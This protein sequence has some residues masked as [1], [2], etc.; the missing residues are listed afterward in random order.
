M[1]YA[2]DF[3]TMADAMPQLVWTA[4]PDGSIDYLNERFIDY[5]GYRPEDI[6]QPHGFERIVHPDDVAA[7]L[8]RWNEALAS[9]EPFETEFRLRRGFD[10]SYRWFL[11]RAL[12]VRNS[13]SEIE[14]W[15]GTA[16]DIDAQKRANESLNLVLDATGLFAAAQDH[17]DLCRRF[18]GLMVQRFADWCV[19]ALYGDDGRLQLCGLR[20]RDPE[21][22]ERWCKLAEQYPLPLDERLKETIE[23][24]TPKIVPLITDD[25]LRRSARSPE[26][27]AELREL[28]LRS[29]IVAPLLHEG[30]ALGAMLLYSAES[31]RVFE[32]ADINVMGTLAERAATAISNVRRIGA[33]HRLRRR[34]QFIGK[35]TEAIYESLDL[36]ASFGEL[37]RL[38]VANFGDFAVTLRLEHETALRVIG[39]AHRDPAKDDIARA[40]V[41][42]RTMHTQAERSFAQSLLD[43]KSRLVRNLDPDTVAESMW[44]YLAQEIIA[45]QPRASITVPLHSRGITYGAIIVYYSCEDRIP[46]ESDEEMLAEIARHASVAME[47]AD[48]FE[49]ERHIAQTLQDSLL[50]PSMPRLE[51]LRFDAVYLPGASAALVGGDWYD[52]WRLEDGAIVINVGDV[53]GRGMDAAIIMGKVRHLMAIAPSYERD[54]ARILDTVESVLGRRYPDVLV[55]AFLGIYDPKQQTLVYAN[56]GHPYPLLRRSMGTEELRAEGLP[57]GLRREAPP[58]ES[59]TVDLSD[60]KLLVLYTDGLTEAHHDVLEGQQRLHEVVNSEAVLHTHN[61]AQFIEESCLG[62]SVDDDVAILTLSFEPSKRWSFDAENARAAQDARG[63]FVHYL[64]RHVVNGSSI[65]AAELVFGELVGNVVRHAPGPIDIDLDWSHEHPI[66]HVIDR[67]KPFEAGGT[68]PPDILSESGRGLYIV[69]QL[70]SD[71]RVEHVPGYGN[72]VTAELPLRRSLE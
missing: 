54:P 61:P 3:R 51:N 52:A 60:A 13:L 1:F 47:N 5:T 58:D 63:E 36:T 11:S 43:H 71:L 66:L 40:L 24:G 49:R 68:L 41:G 4:R 23:R 45:L 9:G 16:T 29:A 69:R 44:P 30:R 70:T 32:Q 6:P 37:M 28:G 35:A 42:V 56:A 64:R 55:T 72:H 17:T 62:G 46:N 27:L 50:P 10:A 31:R 26:H 59:V 67:G 38:I 65:S 48:V 7:V 57:L 19:L 21:K 22:T 15:I 34:L 2:A 33:E 12:P 25:M 39:A 8:E 18:A 14:R 53:T 20:H